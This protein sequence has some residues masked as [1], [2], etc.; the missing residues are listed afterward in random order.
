MNFAVIDRFHCHAT[1][2][3]KIENYPVEKATK[4]GC[5]RTQKNKALLQ[6]LGLCVSP[7]FRYSS[8]CFAEIYR[9]QYENAIL[10]YLRVTPIWRPENSLNIWNLLWI[11][12]RLIISTEKTNIYRRTFPNA[13]T[14]KRAQNQ[15]ISVYFSTN[16][17][18]A[19]CHAPPKLGNS[20]CSGF[21]TKQ[22]IALKNCKQI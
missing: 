22:A 12:R 16:S 19:L 10:V 5:Y 17:I 2:K 7:N 9:A 4:L 1:K 3:I 20:K 15:E 8:K 18:V 6:V 11:S 14:S 13:L 21:Q